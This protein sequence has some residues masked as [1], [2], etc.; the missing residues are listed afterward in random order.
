MRDI[1]TLPF[2]ESMK[3]AHRVRRFRRSNF[4]HGA[5]RRWR[6]RTN[7]PWKAHSPTTRSAA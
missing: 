7:K 6:T 3:A 2:H 1:T 5:E 4:E